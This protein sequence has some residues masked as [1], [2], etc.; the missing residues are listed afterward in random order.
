[1][2]SFYTPENIRKPL[3]F[4]WLQ[5]VERESNGMKW[6]KEIFLMETLKGSKINIYFHCTKNEVFR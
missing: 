3:G 6:F 4:S 2:V 5:G 1:M